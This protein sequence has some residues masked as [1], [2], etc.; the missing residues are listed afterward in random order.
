MCICT[1]LQKE[2]LLQTI[3]PVLTRGP[4]SIY[5]K[6]SFK[7]MLDLDTVEGQ[8]LALWEIKYWLNV[9]TSPAVLT[10]IM[11]VYSGKSI[12]AGGVPHSAP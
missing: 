8:L 9:L 6:L 1:V 11:V 4:E 5:G 12:N 3:L 7:L 10:P 2:N